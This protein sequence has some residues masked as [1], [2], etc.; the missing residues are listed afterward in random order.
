MGLYRNHLI[1][2]Q[3]RELRRQT[4]RMPAAPPGPALS[5]GAVSARR[6][7]M[8]TALVLTVLLIIVMAVSG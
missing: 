7:L 2:T 6:A 8:L 5:P 1:R 3:T 4:A